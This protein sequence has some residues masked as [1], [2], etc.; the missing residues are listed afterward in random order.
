ML[1]DPV[2]DEDRR[3]QPRALAREYRA[4]LARHSW[5]SPP[6]GRFLSIGPD[7]L[8]F[9]RVIQRVVRR[10]GLPAHGET[11]AVSAVSAV[12]RFVYG[13]G[14]IEGHFLDRATE[15][16]LTPDEYHRHAVDAV[17]RSPDAA[18]VVEEPTGAVEARG[19]DTVEEALER[20]FASAPDL[21]VA[22]IEAMV[23]RGRGRGDRGAVLTPPR[24][25]A[26]GTRRSPP[27]PTARE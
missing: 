9:S 22:G 17:T 8:A 12:F 10:T 1:P 26:P 19:G 7:A 23:A 21:L 18:G 15:A 16:G 27:G 24:P 11:G 20:D 4:L 6:A 25:A 5:L 13:H 2:A 3:G 14:T